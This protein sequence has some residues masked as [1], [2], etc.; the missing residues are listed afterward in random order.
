MKKAE[1]GHYSIFWLECPYCGNSHEYPHR[2]TVDAVT[3]VEDGKFTCPD[4]GKKSGVAEVR[5]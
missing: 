4:C 1:G 3:D 5:E 2:M